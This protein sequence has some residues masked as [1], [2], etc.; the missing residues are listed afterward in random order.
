MNP[1]VYHL[2][3]ALGALLVIATLGLALLRQ[4]LGLPGWVWA[5]GLCLLF[6]LWSAHAVASGGLLGFW[7]EHVRNAWSNQI[8]LDLLCAAGL[9]FVLLLP[10]ARAV[11]MQPA[12]WAVAVLATGSVGL[13]AMAA[14]CLW[15]ERA[16]ENVNR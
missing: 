14:R 13:L 6:A 8:W 16:A 11:G 15:L 3:P 4:Q 10:R 7:A 9:A 2:V 1:M 12:W 5:L